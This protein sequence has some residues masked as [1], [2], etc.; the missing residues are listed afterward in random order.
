MLDHFKAIA[1]DFD[2]TLSS[3]YSPR[4]RPLLRNCP[5]SIYSS[6]AEDED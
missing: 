6:F 1:A 3:L 2:S 4:I 5:T